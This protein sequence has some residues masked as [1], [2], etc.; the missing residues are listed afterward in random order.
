LLHTSADL[1][2]HLIIADRIDRDQTAGKTKMRDFS[3]IMLIMK[4]ESRADLASGPGFVP[5]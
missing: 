4:K 5:L 3:F 1:F 2:N